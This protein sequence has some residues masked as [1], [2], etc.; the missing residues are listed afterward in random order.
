[1]R[2]LR[3]TVSGLTAEAIPSLLQRLDWPGETSALR[4]VLD[5]ARWHGRRI[6]LGLDLTGGV[7]GPSLGIELSPFGPDGWEQLLGAAA[8][9][10]PI[11]NGAHA[12]LLAWPGESVADVGWPSR[13]RE[14]AGRIVRRLNH[15]KF[16]VD[17]A[18]SIRL[19]AY[20]YFGLVA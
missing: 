1:L 5:V 19:K 9:L 20:L 4:Q 2:E 17:R 3:A 10:T 12:A 15:L 8:L 13:L 11:G 18:G 14:D 7:V 6:T 16:G